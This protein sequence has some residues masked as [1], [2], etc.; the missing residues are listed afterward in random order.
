MEESKEYVLQHPV[1]WADERVEKL[2]INRPKGKHMRA[3]K[4]I[5]DMGWDEMI[6]LLAKC[7]GVSSKIVDEMEMVDLYGAVEV[8]GDFLERGRQTGKNG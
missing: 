1:T 4:K 7:S 5:G 2:V 8:M 6:E 3:V